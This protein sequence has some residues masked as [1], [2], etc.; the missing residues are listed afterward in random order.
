[1]AFTTLERVTFLL[2]KSGFV[3]YKASYRHVP[4]YTVSFRRT[5]HLGTASYCLV[6]T[7]I[8]IVSYREEY[9]S[10]LEF[11]RGKAKTFSR[12]T[13]LFRRSTMLYNGV[14]RAQD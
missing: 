8:Q 1:M 9:M 4:P 5:H 11:S 3:T 2:E 12:S 6:R 14:P 10:K 13:A 7:E